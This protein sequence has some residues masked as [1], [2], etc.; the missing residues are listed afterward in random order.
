MNNPTRLKDR[1]KD[2]LKEFVEPWS[3]ELW[4][5]GGS[6]LSFAVM[7]ALLGAFDGRPIFAWKGVTLNGIISVLS[8]CMKASLMFAV[9]EC[10]GQWK[11]VLLSQRTRPLIVFERIDQASRGPYGSLKVLWSVGGS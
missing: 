4:A 3:A 7:V 10:M 8:V 1:R 6:S 9:A 2:R 5:L 11:W